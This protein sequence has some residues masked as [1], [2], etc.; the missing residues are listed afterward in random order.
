MSSSKVELQP[1]PFT[2]DYRNLSDVPEANNIARGDSERYNSGF[3]ENMFNYGER[4]CLPNSPK[5]VAP[6]GSQSESGQ[7]LKSPLQNPG[8]ISRE[9]DKYLIDPG[10]SSY[11]DGWNEEIPS[12][13]YDQRWDPKYGS[14]QA[15]SRQ[16]YYD[17]LQ[18]WSLL[19][20]AD[21]KYFSMPSQSQP[22]PD[23][24]KQA[25]GS[26]PS[27]SGKVSHE[28]YCDLQIPPRVL[29]EENHAFPWSHWAK[30]DPEYEQGQKPEEKADQ[31]EEEEASKPTVSANLSVEH[32]NRKDVRRFRCPY[33]K[34]A[35]RIKGYLT[36]HVKKH[37]K[38]KPYTCPYW[39]KSDDTPCHS[40]GGFSRKD[41]YK[42]H[43]KA[44]HFVYPRG[45]FSRDRPR[46]HGRCGGCGRGFSNN[47]VWIEGHIFP[48]ECTG[49]ASDF[50]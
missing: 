35:F 3:Q 40:T 15:Y 46:S 45:V 25:A 20:S 11:D 7:M 24:T 21:G 48:G 14:Y 42:M 13:A 47:E 31:E 49:F 6:I 4:V 44:R 33:C 5:S 10:S 28:S 41:T 43:L 50:T 39:S 37:A 2:F 27:E 19:S 22:E 38:Y 29:R 9:L 16:M 18:Q 32:S 1:P 12:Q 34:Q 30:Q 36:R 23:V 26:E 8:N 17:M